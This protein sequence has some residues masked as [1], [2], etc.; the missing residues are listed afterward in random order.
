[1]LHAGAEQAF[2][3]TLLREQCGLS[4]LGVGAVYAYSGLLVGGMA[5][6]AGRVFDVRRKLL[7]TMVVCMVFSGT[8]QALTGLCNYQDRGA[9]RDH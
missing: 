8:F 6:V 5:F 3:P 4:Q 2:F 1:M 9:R 7:S